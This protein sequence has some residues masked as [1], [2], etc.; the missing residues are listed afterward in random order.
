MG[1]DLFAVSWWPINACNGKH[2][3][4]EEKIAS[5][6]WAKKMTVRNTELAVP[7]SGT[8]VEQEMTNSRAVVPESG[9]AERKFR[10]A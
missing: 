8:R 2:D 6:L 1:P 4:P 10:A 3:Y 7:E 5:N 9:T